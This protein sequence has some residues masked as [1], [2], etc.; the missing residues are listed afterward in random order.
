MQANS[1]N[2]TNAVDPIGWLLLRDGHS[3]PITG[4]APPELKTASQGA[5]LA[6]DVHLGHQRRLKAIVNCLGFRGDFGDYVHR[7]WPKVQAFLCA[8]GC[9]AWRNLF[10]VDDGRTVDLYFG[11]GLGPT[12]RQLADRIFV[13]DR[14][15]PSR[16]FL[17]V[18]ADWGV[19]I[20]NRHDLF[21]QWGFLDDKLV[22]GE[23]DAIVDK[24]YHATS[25]TPGELEGHK[26]QVL[27]A[28]LAFRAAFPEDGPGWVDVLRLEGNDRLVVLRARDGTWDLVWRDLRETAPPPDKE[29]PEYYALHAVDLPTLLA[30]E[31]DL[32]RQL[33]F[34]RDLWEEREAHVA[35]Q[36]FYDVGNTITQRQLATSEQVLKTWLASTGGWPVRRL[37]ST[38]ERPPAGFRSINVAGRMLWISELISVGEYR[39]MLAETS[40]LERRAPSSEDWLRANEPATVPTIAPVGA[41]WND[42][43]AFC[44]WKERSL[45]RQLR[46]PTLAEFRALRPF[47]GPHY[48]SLSQFDF[49]WENYPPRPLD[50]PETE[51]RVVSVP[52]AVLWSEPRFLDPDPERGIPEFP[53]AGGWSSSGRRKRWITDFPPRAAWRDDVWAEHSGLRFIDAWDAY[54]WAQEP[55][56]VSGRFWEGAIG[57]DSWGAYKNAKISFRVVVV[58]Q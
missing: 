54:E 36:H 3:V 27:A 55:G 12:R 2:K 10:A 56:M 49:P 30:G 53:G 32:A 52:S 1:N 23:L 51:A 7:H 18:E 48:Q 45:G 44:A 25:R 41:T 31:Q 34:R 33:Y 13:G 38:S 39:Q 14:P 15:V 37:V 21:G 6:P 24:T 4:L 5:V 20:A 42:A 22:V 35:E 28:V 47:H 17:G 50:G 9:G 19:Q 8:Q 11:P 57:A 46:L 43:Q 40:Y 16:V 58:T 29:V 26:A